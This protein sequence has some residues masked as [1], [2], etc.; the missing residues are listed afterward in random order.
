MQPSDIDRVVRDDL[1]CLWH[2]FTQMADWDSPVVIESAE[3]AWL[4]GAD[5]K[6]YLDGVSSLWCNV[7]GHRCAEIDAAIRAQL[8]KVAHTTL[9]GLTS[10]PAAR[11]ARRLIDI[12]PRGLAK[13]FFSDDGATACEIALKMAFDY[14]QLDGFAERTEFIAVGAGYHGDTVGAVGLGGVSLF[15]RRYAPLLFKTH[16]IPPPDMYRLPQGVT[17]E[18]ALAHYLAEAGHV[19][20]AHAGASCGIFMEPLVQGA[21]GMI[22]HPPGFLRGMRA[23]ADKYGLLLIADEVATGFGRTG[24]MFAC[25]HEGVT[26]DIICLAKG[27]TG[28]YLP[29]AAT[30]ATQAVFGK[31]LDEPSGGPDLAGMPMIM[32]EKGGSADFA[33]KSPTRT[34]FHGHTYTGNTLACAAALA[35]LDIFERE[36]TLDKLRPK[37]ARLRGRAEELLNHPH[38]G[39]VRI[40]GFM[41]G[42]ELVADKG[43]KTPFPASARVGRRV[44]M[45][46]R[47]KGVILRPL[48]DVIVLM[49]PLC[50]TVEEIDMLMDVIGECIEEVCA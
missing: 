46:A 7:H 13:V 14:W 48:G 8:D 11:L 3:G 10:A 22:A 49:P 23:L 16:F 30:L 31:F 34:F 45:A 15:H 32:D 5:G 40:C 24:K 1:D 42:I 27:I 38:V 41:G 21:G 26:P 44:C 6:R 4:V 28:G 20:A 2:P 50:V 43:S 18:G 36:K 19:V 17:R 9:L 12:A 39:D 37:A 33:D 29:L 25:E 47:E 35:S